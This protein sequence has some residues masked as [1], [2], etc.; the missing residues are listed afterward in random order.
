MEGEEV[1]DRIRGRVRNS[2][3]KIRKISGRRSLGV[4]GEFGV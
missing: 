1:I 4:G 2:G 3:R